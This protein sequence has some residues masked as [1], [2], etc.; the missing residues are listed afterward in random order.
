MNVR[1]EDN[2]TANV[3]RRW[4]IAW[5]ATMPTIT[6]GAYF[7]LNGTT[8]SVVTLKGTTETRVTSGAFNGHLGFT[9]SPTFT[10]NVVFEI[11][12]TTG[13][14]YFFIADKLVHKV[15]ASTASWTNTMSFHV[16]HDVVN[17]GNS[18]AVAMYLR[19][20]SIYRIGQLLT[21]PTSYY[22]AAGQTAGVNLKVGAGNLHSIIINNVVNNAVITLADSTSGATPAIFV[23]TAGATSTSAYSL[24]M[25]GL[26]FFT[27]LRLI[28]ASANA[29]VTIIY[30]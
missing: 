20:S 19:S 14:V 16:W 6:D 7:E 3:K 12:Y 15:T 17:S 22:L 9:Y 5:G 26:P 2:G 18:S 24:D 28:V 29:S 1:L 11:L 27:G 30:E 8:F 23:H 25:K 10:N 21:Q 13:S 4:G